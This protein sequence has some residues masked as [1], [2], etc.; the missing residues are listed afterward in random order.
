MTVPGDRRSPTT[1][2]P[3]PEVVLLGDSV[4]LGLMAQVS[5]AIVL[6][7]RPETTRGPDASL[8]RTLRSLQTAVV[9]V[10]APPAD[11][12][13]LGK[14][15]ALRRSRSGIRVVLVDRAAAPDR[16][17]AALEAG[18]DEALPYHLGD[19]EIAGR[20]AIQLARARATT[21]VRLAVGVGVELDIEARALRRRGRFVH[22]RPLEFRLLE[23]LARAPGRPLSR[24]WLMERA[25]GEAPAVGSRTIDVHIRWLRE[26]VER[27]PDQP[28]HILTV[29]GVG[30]QL[31]PQDPDETRPPMKDA[32]PTSPGRTVDG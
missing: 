29:R 26:K 23:E 25:W 24:A 20:V 16:R 8:E 4:S 3:S 27:D 31:E 9:V 11:D 1:G 22:L 10:V 6:R 5:D 17:L 7:V 21:P 18:F 2:D 30:Y 14:V 12:A 28:V 32:V 15:A 19:D 13:L